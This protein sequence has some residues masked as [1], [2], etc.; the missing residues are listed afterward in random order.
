[1]VQYEVEWWWWFLP[2][3]LENQTLTLVWAAVR[4]VWG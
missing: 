3:S 4:W 2:K 1:M